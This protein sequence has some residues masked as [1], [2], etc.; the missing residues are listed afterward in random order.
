M[1]TTRP[2]PDRR[3]PESWHLDKKVPLSLIFAMLVQAGMVIA[4][5]ADIKEDVEVLKSQMISQV[6]RDARQDSDMKETMSLLRD[7]LAALNQKMDRLIER[8]NK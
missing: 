5:V 4:A 8:G 2:N 7:Q 3:A 1:V 6:A